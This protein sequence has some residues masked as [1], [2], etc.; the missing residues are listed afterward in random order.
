M[1]VKP[2]ADSFNLTEILP[3]KLLKGFLTNK[4]PVDAYGSIITAI[5]SFLIIPNSMLI[6]E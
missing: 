6:A 2:G 3:Q 4:L 5:I 1:R